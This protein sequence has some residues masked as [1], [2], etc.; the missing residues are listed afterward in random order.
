MSNE[1]N[2]QSRLARVASAAAIT[3]AA[4]TLTFTAVGGVYAKSPSSAAAYYYGKITICHHAGPHGK[5][6]T[7]TVS[8]SALPAHLRHGDTVGPCP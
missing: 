8:Q 4:V 7:I 6:V 2:E 1:R 5:T 3:V